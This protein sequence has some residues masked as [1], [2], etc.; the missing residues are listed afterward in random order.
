MIGAASASALINGGELPE[1]AGRRGCCYRKASLGPVGLGGLGPLQLVQCHVQFVRIRPAR[2]VR[3]YFGVG[4][5]AVLIDHLA[6]GH[7]QGPTRLAAGVAQDRIA[8][9]V[10]PLRLPALRR[11]L[12]G[13]RDQNSAAGTDFVR[14]SRERLQIE[15]AE[16]APGA[17]VERQRQRSLGKRFG[18]GDAVAVLVRKRELRWPAA[19]GGDRRLCL[20]TKFQ[21]V[22]KWTESTL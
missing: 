22:G 8:Q 2:V 14:R 19:V 16:R 5:D 10:G 1:I 21:A 18:R 7:R 11:G 4:D 12:L 6:C 9:M 13:Y 3:I 20:E 17:A 15:I